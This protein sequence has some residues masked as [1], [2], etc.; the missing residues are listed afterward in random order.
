MLRDKHNDDSTKLTSVATQC[1][2]Q[3]SSFLGRNEICNNDLIPLTKIFATH[4]SAVKAYSYT[5]VST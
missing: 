5:L 3:V 4:E 2:F 1:C